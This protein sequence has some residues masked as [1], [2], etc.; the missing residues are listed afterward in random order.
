MV[1]WKNTRKACSPGSEQ[2][3]HDHGGQ[4]FLENQLCKNFPLLV[5]LFGSG[6]FFDKAISTSVNSGGD[7]QGQR[8]CVQRKRSSPTPPHWE[9]PLLFSRSRQTLWCALFS[10]RHSL[11]FP[12][13]R[14]MSQ[15]SD[16]VK[17]KDDFLGWIV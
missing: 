13:P 17:K 5:A 3:P 2:P 14:L 15:F 16:R 7:D 11:W 9:H 10:S 6:A 1:T 12:S 4:L 8:H